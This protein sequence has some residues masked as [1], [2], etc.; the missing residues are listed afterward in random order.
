VHTQTA[1]VCAARNLPSNI[2]AK[3]Y[4]TCTV[5]LFGDA[6]VQGLSQQDRLQVVL[7]QYSFLE[8]LDLRLG[9]P[10]NPKPAGKQ[11]MLLESSALNSLQQQ[12][13]IST[14]WFV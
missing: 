3:S 13:I 12:A 1:A 2:P 5:Q 9:T 7:L 14:Q 6:S 11:K 10:A 8:K 4:D